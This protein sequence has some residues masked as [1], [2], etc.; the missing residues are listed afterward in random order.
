MI[1]PLRFPE[2]ARRSE[3]DASWA[4][5]GTPETSGNAISSIILD[6]DRLE[7]HNIHLQEKYAT[8]RAEVEWEEYRLEDALVILVAYGISSRLAR[9]VV[10]QARTQGIPAG[11]LRP[12]TLYPFPSEPLRQLA[13][14]RKGTVF[15]AVEMSNGQMIDDVKLAI[16]GASPVLLANRMGGNVITEDIIMAGVREAGKLA[17]C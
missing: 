5:S 10:D 9:T 7:S 12:K 2:Q 8:M 14:N 16:E 17:G 1:E 3:I 11:L 15:L 4:V 13:A 6:F